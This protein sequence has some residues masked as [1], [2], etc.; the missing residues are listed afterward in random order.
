MISFKDR[1]MEIG[2]DKLVDNKVTRFIFFFYAKFVFF[3][4]YVLSIT[5][6]FEDQQDSLLAQFGDGG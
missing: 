5:G 1:D 6:H 2:F 4:F 3:C